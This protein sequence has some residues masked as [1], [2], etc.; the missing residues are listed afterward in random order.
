MRIQFDSAKGSDDRSPT[1]EN[2]KVMADWKL[3]ERQPAAVAEESEEL[4]ALQKKI[5]DLET[6]SETQSSIIAE[7]AEPSRLS[8]YV[9]VNRF[10]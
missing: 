5:E 9:N 3:V 8:V 1:S 6:L 7:M 10:I 2:S 4:A